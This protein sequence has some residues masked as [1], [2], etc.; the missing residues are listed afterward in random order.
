MKDNPKAFFAHVNNRKPIKNTIGPLRDKVGNII[1]NDKDMASIL[2]EY[3]AS[4]YTEEDI[5]EIPIVPIVYQGDKPLRK[6]E[7]TVE[8]V[9]MKIRKLKSS[10]SAGPDG[11]HPR[12]IKETEEEA[13]PYFCEIYRAS[14]KQRKA[15]KDWKLQNIAPFFK[16]GSKDDPGNY[17]PISLTTVPGKM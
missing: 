10:K 4:V 12:V 1:S 13:A 3:F 8:K 17:R 16:K 6:I 15:V 2:N 9:R 5:S 7:V 11:Y 14:L